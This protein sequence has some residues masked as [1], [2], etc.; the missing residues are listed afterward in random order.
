MVFA[1]PSLAL[2]AFDTDLRQGDRGT[3]V[4]AL[5]QFLIAQRLLSADNATGFFGSLTLAA[6]RAFQSQQGISPIS[7]FFGPLTRAR[8]DALLSGTGGYTTPVADPNGDIIAQIAALLEQVKRL[9][10]QIAALSV[11]PV[12]PTPQP[13]S[14][15]A[16]PASGSAPLAVSFSGS[17]LSAGYDV[18]FGD[19]TQ[20]YSYGCAHGGCPI[21]SYSTNV[22]ISHTYTSA[23]TYTAKLRTHFAQNAGNCAGSDCNVVGTATITVTGNS[24]QSFRVVSPNG[25][26]TVRAGTSVV[27][28]WNTDGAS[29]GGFGKNV[30]TLSLIPS[31]PGY[32]EVRQL[33]IANVLASDLSYAWTPAM[34]LAGD[35]YRIKA[36]LSDGTCV[37]I[38]PLPF[39]GITCM[40]V[41]QTLATDESDW[42]SIEN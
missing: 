25:G 30:V 24:S 21:G 20:P 40:A 28:R 19:G 29:I 6:V 8:A 34:T 10:A 11:N 2:A 39:D 14:F 18:N 1:L 31:N 33:Q 13:M 27:I 35:S 3:A 22:A 36:A 26:E 4:V 42:F 7:G 16:A 41:A 15:I 38:G 9:Q 5:Q 17:V 37:P 32:K 12:T 23:G